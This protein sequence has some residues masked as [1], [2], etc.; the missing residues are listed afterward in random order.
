MPK[1]TV[2]Y[3]RK[4]VDFYP[5]VD[6]DK[7]LIE[8]FFEKDRFLHPNLSN[9]PL[10]HS[11]VLKAALHYF[12]DNVVLEEEKM[13]K[14]AKKHENRVLELEEEREKKDSEIASLKSEVLRLR[15][16]GRPKHQSSL[17]KEVNFE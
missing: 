17:R 1:K 7:N 11:D 8:F 14:I 9:V 3:I 6:Y 15:E 16:K 12:Y 5:D 4:R 13:E 10:S 2:N